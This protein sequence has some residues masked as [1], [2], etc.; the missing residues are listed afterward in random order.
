VSYTMQA[1]EQANLDK[2]NEEKEKTEIPTPMEP[3]VVGLI[4]SFIDDSD[5]SA[6][7]G[8]L[9]KVTG[10]HWALCRNV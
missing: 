3:L 6:K 4:K 1:S 7:L 8:S 5:L 2:I 10:S 9:Y